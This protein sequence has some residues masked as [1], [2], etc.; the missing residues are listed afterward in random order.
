[1]IEK[2][3]ETVDDEHVILT[4]TVLDGERIRSRRQYHLSKLEH[5]SAEEVCRAACPEA[6]TDSFIEESVARTG[7]Q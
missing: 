3:I 6:F 1:M 5:Q 7:G 4:V 2:T